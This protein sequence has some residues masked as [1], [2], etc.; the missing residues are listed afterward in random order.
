MEKDALVS[1]YIDETR[2]PQRSIM[3]QVRELIAE[4]VPNVAEQYK[5]SRPVYRVEKD[6]TYMQ[7]NKS[8]VSLGFYDFEKLSDPDTLLEGS[9]KTM[10]HIKLKKTKDIDPDLLKSW[11]EAT[12]R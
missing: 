4:V 9:G 1:Q 3:N 7:S 11:F 6:F 8:H 10:R 2:E 5:W 12:A